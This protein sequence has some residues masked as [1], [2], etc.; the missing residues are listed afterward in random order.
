MEEC[1]K[2]LK[3]LQR[4]IIEPSDARDKLLMAWAEGVITSEEFEILFRE[5]I[6]ALATR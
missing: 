4:Q 2:I 5:Y 6:V 3:L 1:R